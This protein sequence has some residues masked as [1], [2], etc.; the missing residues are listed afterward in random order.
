MSQS[1]AKTSLKVR[2]SNLQ[3]PYFIKRYFFPELKSVPM[4]HILAVD[5][6]NSRVKFGVFEVGAAAVPQLVALSA[7]R[8]DPDVCMAEKI[9]SW[10]AEQQF[11]IIASTIVAG[12]NPPVTNQLL[13]NWPQQPGTLTVID[14]GRSIPI[15]VDVDQPAAV[16]I[17]R[18]LTAFAGRRLVSDQQPLIVIDSGTATTVNLITADGTFRGGAILPGLRLSACALHDY[19]AKLPLLDTDQLSTSLQHVDAPLPGRNTQDAM[20]AGLFWGQLGAIREISNRLSQA[21]KQLG[22]SQPPLSILTGGGGRQL[23]NHLP[24]TIYIDSLALHGLALLAMQTRT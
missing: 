6:G 19:T 11:S 5:V 7:V 3:Y 2:P 10:L 18:L 24:G 15:A 20:K 14:D 16:G 12:S 13:G 21:A 9:D 8:I 22:D 1:F 23:V 17:D 4:T